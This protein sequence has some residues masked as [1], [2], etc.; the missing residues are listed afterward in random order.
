MIPGHNEKSTEESAWQ[1]PVV[2]AFKEQYPDVTVEFVT[3]GWDTWYTK[4][5]SAYKSG[6][7]IDLINDGA[8][9]NPKFALK[10]ITQPLEKF[11]NMDNKNLHKTTM[12][13]VFKYNNHY[14]VAVSETNVAVVY[15]N[16]NLF[17]SEGVDDPATLYEQGKW[18][19]DN[20]YPRCQGADQ[21]SG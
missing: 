2:A 11:V 8:N 12:D 3:A 9:N 14:Y 19:W 4:V 15:Y 13:S 7:P 6:E 1:N 18:D 10:G 16:K 20:L 5:L 21:R 17:Q